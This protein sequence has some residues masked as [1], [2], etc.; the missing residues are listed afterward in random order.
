VGLQSAFLRERGSLLRS[1]G[2]LTHDPS[3]DR[4]SLRDWQPE[5]LDLRSIKLSVTDY[6]CAE[7]HPLNSADLTNSWKA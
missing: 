3:I 1:Y 2:T 6:V 7:A 4:S 5:V